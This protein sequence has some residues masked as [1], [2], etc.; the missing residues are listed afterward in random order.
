MPA[1][2][3]VL[4]VVMPLVE[5]YVL[6]KVGGLVGV[7][8]TIGLL[9][10]ASFLGAWL[11]RREGARTWE[12]FRRA[13]DEGRVPARET[14]DGALVIFGGA[15][16]LTPGFVSD[17]LGL[18][19]VLPPTRALVRGLVMGVVTAHIAP[20]RWFE[21]GRV[22]VR[23]AQRVQRYA[24]KRADKKRAANAAPPAQLPPE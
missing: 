24:A 15:L 20:L 11:V 14:A 5:L 22:G 16:L 13:M 7:L 17:V 10:V 1:L 9:L 6:L 12:A 8:P 18:L 3:L 23:R 19:C 21:A 4:F 2:L